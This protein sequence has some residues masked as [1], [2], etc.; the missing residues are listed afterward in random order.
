MTSLKTSDY[1]ADELDLQY[2]ARATV[3]DATV[4]MRE[5][6]EFTKSAK[7]VI[8]HLDNLKYGT[9]PEEL[10]DIYLAGRQNA[11]VLVFIHGGYWRALS[12][13]DS[14]FMAP[15]FTRAS[16]MV[17]ALDYALAPVVT[18]DTIV[19]QV[20][21]AI[22]WIRENIGQYGGDPEQLF[23]C[24]SSA[25]GHLTGMLLQRGW[26]EQYGVPLNVIKGAVPVSGLFDLRPLVAT[27]INEWLRHD[28]DD[29]ERNS[30]ILDLVDVKCPLIA[31]YAENDTHEFKRQSI[32]FADR[33]QKLG[34]SV[35]VIEVSNTNH[36]DVLY[37]MMNGTSGLSQAIL[38]MMGL[39]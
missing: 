27:H 16:A 17:V 6:G 29:A 11:P 14:G 33:W 32:S 8:P 20:R 34:N 3:A 13:D 1:T 39:R 18:L 22:A 2:N 38:A 31:A 10:L 25:G 19:H 12:K 28:L 7:Q 36:F 21:T 24:G 15:T 23:V 35:Q 5:Y 30:P 37:E 26:H 4:Y 9:T